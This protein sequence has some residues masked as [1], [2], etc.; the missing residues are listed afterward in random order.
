MGRALPGVWRDWDQSF[1]SAHAVHLSPP[2]AT[3]KETRSSGI[4]YSSAGARHQA[5]CRN[6]ASP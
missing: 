6:Y 5:H 4:P 1:I 3:D 2:V